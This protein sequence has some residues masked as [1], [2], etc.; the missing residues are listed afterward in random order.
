LDGGGEAGKGG[1]W[2]TSTYSG[3]DDVFLDLAG[4]FLGKN[5][6]EDSSCYGTEGT[7]GAGDNGFVF[8]N[9]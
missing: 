3:W 7:A 2:E 8:E 6:D 9:G 5:C 4:S 1:G